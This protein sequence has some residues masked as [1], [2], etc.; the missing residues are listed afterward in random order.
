MQILLRQQIDNIYEEKP[1]NH[2]LRQ[3]ICNPYGAPSN[4]GHHVTSFLDHTFPECLGKF[5]TVRW[6]PR[7][8]DLTP[9]DFF[10]EIDENFIHKIQLCIT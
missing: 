1:M 6:R 3:V 7:T 10:V 4:D 5:G 2:E 9:L 8:P